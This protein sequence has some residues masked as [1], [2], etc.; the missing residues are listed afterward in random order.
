A[1]VKP[2][3]EV[4]AVDGS[5]RAIGGRAGQ[6][7][8]VFALQQYGM[9]QV[10]YSGTDNSWRWRK[11]EGDQRHIAFWGQIM[12]RLALPHLLGE[13]KRTQLTLDRATYFAGDRVTV[14]ARLFATAYLPIDLP[15]ITA[16]YASSDGRSTAAVSLRPLP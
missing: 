14:Y 6:K 15:E 11:N 7:T 4:L 8:P 9:G 3:A 12:Q 2:G 13:S 16:T 1:G 10:F 5:S